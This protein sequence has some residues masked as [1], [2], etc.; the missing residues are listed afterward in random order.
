MHTRNTSSMSLKG[1]Q[2]NDSHLS[3]PSRCYLLLVLEEI[4]HNCNKEYVCFLKKFHLRQPSAVKL[5]LKEY[6]GLETQCI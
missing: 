3:A 6:T 5:G 2:C 1:N 4:L